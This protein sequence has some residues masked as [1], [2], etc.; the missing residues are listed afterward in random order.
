MRRGYW[1]VAIP[2][3]ML[4]ATAAIAGG[5]SCAVFD[6][7]PYGVNAPARGTPNAYTRAVSA[8]FAW[9]RFGVRWDLVQPGGYLTTPNFDIPDCPDVPCWTVASGACPSTNQAINDARASE[10]SVMVAIRGTPAWSVRACGIDSCLPSCPG[11]TCCSVAGSGGS[12][13]GDPSRPCAQD[14]NP[15]HVPGHP[16][17]F[18]DFMR[19]AAHA[20]GD[21][22][23]VFELWSEP[24]DRADYGGPSTLWN[25]TAK[26]YRNYILAPGFDGVRQAINDPGGI[27]PGY[28]AAPDFHSPYTAQALPVTGNRIA[29]TNANGLPNDNTMLSYIQWCLNTALNRTCNGG[30]RIG[31]ACSSDDGHPTTGCPGAVCPACCFRDKP[32]INDGDCGPGEGPC[33]LVR[34]FNFLSFTANEQPVAS[35][36]N[37]DS[38]QAAVDNSHAEA[39]RPDLPGEFIVSEF[40]FNQ[41]Q[42][43][44][45][46][47]QVTKVLDAGAEQQG[48]IRKCR[49]TG[50]CTLAFLDF[51]TDRYKCNCPGPPPVI[52]CD[53]GLLKV[54]GS[55]R[56]RY[57]DVMYEQSK[58]CSGGPI[59]GE[60]C[61][62]STDCFGGTCVIGG[63]TS[64]CP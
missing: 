58:R 56:P 33:E 9:N 35:K 31:Q 39:T 51:L 15:G 3:V 6:I 57:C 23:A 12:Q 41:A 22:A 55:H 45:G 48:M 24:N 42:D 54:D 17:H 49:N 2:L 32:C 4:R 46:S 16:D 27:C 21:R 43:A 8:N 50:G 7:D 53:L 25:G 64:P 5:G 47:C 61:S 20:L 28:V 10:L 40:S 59:P 52:N 18:R 13:V 14:A 29:H 36:Q 26:D 37:L 44:C 63:Y 19:K 34:V 62:T 60:V 11:G 30:S 1:V 38:I